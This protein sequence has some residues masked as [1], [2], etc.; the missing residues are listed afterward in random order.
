MLAKGI[1]VIRLDIG[2]PDM[3]P[4]AD[5]IEILGV[6]AQRADAHGYAGYR[7]TPGIR[8]A[9]ADY[10]QR[11]F[12]VTLNPDQEV[13]PLLGSKEGIVNLCLAYL[14]KGDLALVPTI[15]YPSYSLGAL[16]AG[17]EVHWMPVSETNGYTPDM[18]AI[19]EHALDRAKLLWV[20]FPNNPTGATVALSFYEQA[21]D[22]CKRHNLL[23]VSDN[24][25]AD[26]TFDGYRA[27]SALEVA[28]AKD[29]TIEFA[30]LS[31]TFNMA[32]W[33][34]GAAVGNSE[35]LKTLLQVKSN[36][37]SGHFI[38]I[39]EAAAHA[40]RTTSPEWLTERNRIYQHRRDALVAAL[41]E[42]G[43]KGEK[44]RGSL[45]VWA[46]A[47]GGMSGTDYCDQALEHA[48]VALVPGSAY[49]PDGV[50]Y[51]RFSVGMEDRAFS[52]ALERLKHWWAS[53]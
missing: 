32:G 19:P 35:A 18:N 28:G 5:V 44:P 16:L 25:Y 36:V 29:C 13:L 12:G 42:I 20:N 52:E 7:G 37:D 15:G 31:K 1:P 47:P 9:F 51:I 8:N 6:H 23:L 39:Y 26:V 41:P 33:R 24:P 21:V 49:G 40:L 11:R 10:Y 22:F 17:A 2:N 3:P 48:H 30:S 14:D 43:L 45:Y 50:N 27:P 46:K 34:V 53:R 38:P 4:P